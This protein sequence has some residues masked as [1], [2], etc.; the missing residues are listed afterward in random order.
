MD[1]FMKQKLPLKEKIANIW[2]Y[3]KLHIFIGSIIALALIIGCTQCAMRVE[4]DYKIVL[5]LSKQAPDTVIDAMSD[6][7][8]Q[9][10]ED[11]NG[12]GQVKV[13]IVDACVGYTQ[14]AQ[15]AQSTKL[16]A[17]M[18]YGQT[19]LF[20]TDD[21]YYD[22]LMKF[23]V[24]ESVDWLPD[25]DGTAYNWRD[26]PLADAVNAVYENYISHDVYISKRVV[27]GT[28]FEKIESSVESEKQSVEL[29]KKA[30]A[31]W[32]K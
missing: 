20:I 14:D 23:E 4:P 29:L 27:A 17:E 21:S 31:D 28:D 11:I 8:E 18:Q 32:E 19:M 13:D 1:S 22:R 6:Y 2:Y 10:G 3:Y 26:T 30:I 12:D 25:K 15:A 16:M 5:S 9:F 24:F 7:F